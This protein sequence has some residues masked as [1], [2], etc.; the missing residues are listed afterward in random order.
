MMTTNNSN[1]SI[2]TLRLHLYEAF[3]DFRLLLPPPHIPLTPIKTKQL[4]Q[5]LLTF[6]LNLMSTLC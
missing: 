6:P 5:E 2:S 4:Q 3:S 1:S